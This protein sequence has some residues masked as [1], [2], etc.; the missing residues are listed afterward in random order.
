M[1]V[2]NEGKIFEDCIAESCPEH[3]FVK[4]L[5]DNASGWSGG[6]KTCFATSNECDFIMHDE[7]TGILYGLELKSTK[8]RSFTF[9]REDFE[10]ECKERGKQTH[11]MIGKKQILGLKKWNEKHRG[12]FGFVFNF[13]NDKNETMFVAISD[14]LEYTNRLSSP[15]ISVTEVREMGCIEINSK[16]I[17]TN[18]RYDMDNFFKNWS[19][20]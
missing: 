5:A 1:A 4:K 20:E 10:K 9:W 17:R 7:K 19:R 15:R 11:Y 12:V 18:Y 6:N 14:F 2:K 3:I 16:K 8:G 13:R